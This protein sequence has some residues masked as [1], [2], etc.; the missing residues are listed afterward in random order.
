MTEQRVADREAG[1]VPGISAF[2]WL[3]GGTSLEGVVRDISDGGVKIAGH[4]TGVNVGDILEL[5]LVVQGDQK[6]KYKCEVCHVESDEETYG[7]RFLSG[8]ELVLDPKVTSKRCTRCKREYAL[9]WRFC[10]KCG[11]ELMNA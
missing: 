3:P 2:L 5:I 1:L 4:T 11:C 7:V 6:I 9:E 10:G 8:P